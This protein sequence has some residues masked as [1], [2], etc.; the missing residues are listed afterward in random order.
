MIVS[1][2]RVVLSYYYNATC[3]VSVLKHL[4]CF[5]C[6][7]VLIYKLTLKITSSSITDR[8]DCQFI[9]PGLRLAFSFNT[10]TPTMHY[11]IRRMISYP[12]GYPG[13]KQPGNSSPWVI[14]V[15]RTAGALQYLLRGHP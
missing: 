6:M 11:G 14:A 8:C 15:L 3:F 2:Q 10:F 13:S 9:I 5:L 1:H 4:T 7:A 12:I